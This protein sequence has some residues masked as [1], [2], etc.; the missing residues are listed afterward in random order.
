[1]PTMYSLFILLLQLNYHYY[2]SSLMTYFP[3]LLALWLAAAVCDIHSLFF[4]CG[5][6][7]PFESLPDRKR[8]DT[9]ASD[10]MALLA[11]I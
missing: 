5:C 3:P 7:S 4:H 2:H 9:L 1:M 6:P 10:Q 11:P 8:L